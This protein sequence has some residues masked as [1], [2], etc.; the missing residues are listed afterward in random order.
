MTQI[1]KKN[2]KKLTRK[3]LKEVTMK[4]PRKTKEFDAKK[5]KGSL[6]LLLKSTDPMYKWEPVLSEVK[7]YLV[8]AKSKEISVKKIHK[9]FKESGANM[10]IDVLKNYIENHI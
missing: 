6:D 5:L 9:V 10:P 3:T 8:D 4:T 7:S 2:L 1:F